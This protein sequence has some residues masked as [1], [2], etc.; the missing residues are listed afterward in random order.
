M[1][2]IDMAEITEAFPKI[3]EKTINLWAQS[4]KQD[5]SEPSQ[6]VHEMMRER[7]YFLKYG[8]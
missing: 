7:M 8:E 5:L 6:K 2:G 3:R 4:T 1:S